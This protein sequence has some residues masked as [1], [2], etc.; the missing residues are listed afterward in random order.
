MKKKLIALISFLCYIICWV[1][2]A[3]EHYYFK[4]LSIQDGLSQTTV[5]AIMQDKK[6][7]MWFG[8]KGGLNRYDG[9]SFRNFKHDTTDNHSLGNNFVTC[10]YQDNNGNIWV[11]TDAGVYIYYSD[12]EIFI[13]FDRLSRETGHFIRIICRPVKC[14]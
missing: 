8:T 11:G 2:A 9:M 5:N 3:D 13:P 12:Q 1:Q 7:F 6:G 10:L 4:N 14:E